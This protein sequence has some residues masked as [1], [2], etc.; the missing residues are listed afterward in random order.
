MQS[1]P[2]CWMY[3][4]RRRADRIFGIL[5]GLSIGIS[6]WEIRQKHSG[7]G[8]LPQTAQVRLHPGS[9][10]RSAGATRGCAEVV[11]LHL[12]FGTRPCRDLANSSDRRQTYLPQAGRAT[13][14]R[15][16]YLG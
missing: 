9:L 8:A 12:P 5:E 1:E 4:R 3:P 7:H 13:I 14:L 11:Q 10:L 6:H 15:A 2:V 16:G